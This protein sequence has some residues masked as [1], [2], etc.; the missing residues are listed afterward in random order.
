MIPYFDGDS[1]MA[2]LSHTGKISR[3]YFWVKTIYTI[4]SIPKSDSYYLDVCLVYD[5]NLCYVDLTSKNFYK[6]GMF[7]R[8]YGGQEFYLEPKEWTYFGNINIKKSDA[9]TLIGGDII[10][11]YEIN[12]VI[13]YANKHKVKPIRPF[14][15]ASYPV[16]SD[17]IE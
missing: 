5:L 6:A 2:E 8:N 3:I 11:L 4:G 17:L 7:V 10:A 9:T 1:I 16:P 12:Q 14:D 13:E 15:I